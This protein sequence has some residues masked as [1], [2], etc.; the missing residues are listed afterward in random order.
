[1]IAELAEPRIGANV[2]RHFPR[3]CVVGSGNETTRLDPFLGLARGYARA[4]W[5]LG[6]RLA[7]YKSRNGKQERNETKR[8]KGPDTAVAK[9]SPGSQPA[10]KPT[11]DIPT[12]TIY[13]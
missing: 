3:A 11:L 6:T 4:W 7:S 2:P 13:Y 1:M 5:F 8:V 10:K 9:E 12:Y